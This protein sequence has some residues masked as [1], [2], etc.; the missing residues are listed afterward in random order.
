MNIY[1]KVPHPLGKYI[2][3]AKDKWNLLLIPKN[4]KIY[5]LG[6]SKQYNSEEEAAQDMNL[7]KFASPISYDFT[8][9]KD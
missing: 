3:N 8:K 1:V 9:Q 4:V 5:T 2:D 7:T 6:E